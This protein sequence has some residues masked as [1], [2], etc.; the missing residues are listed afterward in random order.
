MRFLWRGPETPYLWVQYCGFGLIQDPDFVLVHKISLHSEFDLNYW[1][2]VP[3]IFHL[4]TYGLIYLEL[5]DM[6]NSAV[7]GLPREYLQNQWPDFD[8]SGDYHFMCQT[9]ICRDHSRYL[10]F[11]WD[12]VQCYSYTQRPGVSK[13][14]HLWTLEQKKPLKNFVS[15]ENQNHWNSKKKINWPP[16]AV[17]V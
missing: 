2:L 5:C 14:R 3:E 4:C 13:L 15:P 8:G 7:S 17:L 6:R 9:K 11:A 10:N 16:L 1:P 12:Q